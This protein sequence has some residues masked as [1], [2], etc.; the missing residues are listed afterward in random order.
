[1]FLSFS[2]DASGIAELKPLN[3]GS[4]VDCFTNCV[5]TAGKMVKNPFLQ[6]S[7]DDNHSCIQPEDDK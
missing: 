4:L 1:M 7:P 3:L 6:F 2:A 5:T